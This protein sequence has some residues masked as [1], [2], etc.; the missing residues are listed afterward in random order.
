MYHS[1][2]SPADWETLPQPR[3]FPSAIRNLQNPHINTFNSFD[4][5]LAEGSG[6][7]NKILDFD[8]FSQDDK[9]NGNDLSSRW[10]TKKKLNLRETLPKRRPFNYR[11]PTQ[12]L[13][14]IDRYTTNFTN[15]DA[16][17]KVRMYF[18]TWYDK[19]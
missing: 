17:N 5:K 9:I 12:I 19:C 15:T 7:I 4:Q 11:S 13:A 14:N 10:K 2:L 18:K 1:E 16:A 6:I 3:I 8:L